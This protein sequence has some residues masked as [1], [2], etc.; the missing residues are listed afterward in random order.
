MKKST[1]TIVVI[2][3]ILVAVIGVLVLAGRLISSSEKK[4]TTEFFRLAGI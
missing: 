4:E 2:A 1:K 3:V